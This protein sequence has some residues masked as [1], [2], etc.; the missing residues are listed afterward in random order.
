MFITERHRPPELL[1]I[2]AMF[3]RSKLDDKHHNQ[4]ENLRR[5]YEGECIYD[6]I[7]NEVGHDNLYIYRDVYLSIEDST[8]QY[9]SLIVTEEGVVVNEIKN[10][11]GTYTV[12]DG[13]WAKGNF[14]L[15][16]DPFAQLRRAIGKMRRLSLSS[17]LQF[18]VSGKLI[19]PNE[20]CTLIIA[21]E[22]LKQNIIIRSNL[23][24]Y[25]ARFKNSFSGNLAREICEVIKRNIVD[26]P[27]F[28][29]AVDFDDVRHGIYCSECGEFEVEVRRYHVSCLS[30]GSNETRETHLIRAISD[31]KYLFG[32]LPM[33]TQRMMKFTDG[34]FSKRAIQRVLEKYCDRHGMYKSSTYTFKYYDF[35]DAMSDQNIIRRYRD[36]LSKK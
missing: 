19:F 24:R 32:K 9:D 8:T 4:L 1:H 7:F 27:Y 17:D 22:S 13:S 30:C 21:D 31:Y 28:K 26:N 33:T 29:S 3:T 23:R 12:M 2:E 20:E 6:S 5:G 18:K 16:D 10:F 34:K 14:E 36:N 35:E 25:L 15:P 11:S